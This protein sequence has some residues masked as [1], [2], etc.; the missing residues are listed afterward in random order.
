MI[1]TFRQRGTMSLLSAVAAAFAALIVVAVAMT[2]L[3][4]VGV[5]ACSI[6][7]VRAVAGAGAGRSMPADDHAIIE[8]VVVDS[9][10][11]PHQPPPRAIG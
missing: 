6:W 10:D 4:I 9:T 11:V 5:V 8:G 3:V 7:L 1:F 2:T